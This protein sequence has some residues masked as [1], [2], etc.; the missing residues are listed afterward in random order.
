MAQDT[1]EETY[2]LGTGLASNSGLFVFARVLFGL[3]L[4]LLLRVL[5]MGKLKDHNREEGKGVV[6][7]KRM[8]NLEQV[9]DGWIQNQPNKSNTSGKV[10]KATFASSVRNL[11][12]M[13]DFDNFDFDKEGALDE[14]NVKK[15]SKKSKKKSVKSKKFGREKKLLRSEAN[16]VI[17]KNS[18]PVELPEL[19]LRTRKPKKKVPVKFK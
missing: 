16:Q 9:A 14:P 15:S 19:N 4:A 13:E 8:Q 7:Q 2:E 1:E 3:G 5:G 10:K 6:M 17:K 11:N 18:G 12:D